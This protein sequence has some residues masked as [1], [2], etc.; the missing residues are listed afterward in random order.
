MQLYVSWLLCMSQ[1]SICVSSISE[2]HKSFCCYCKNSS[3]IFFKICIK[4]LYGSKLTHSHSFRLSL[5]NLEC[6]VLKSPVITLLYFYTEDAL[7]GRLYQ[8]RSKQDCSAVFAAHISEKSNTRSRWIVCSPVRAWVTLWVVKFIDT[9][10]V[11]TPFHKTWF[12]AYNT[13]N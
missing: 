1:F 6:L 2:K 8:I 3:A 11:F 13:T 5:I 10:T 4:R 7:S 9:N 12:L